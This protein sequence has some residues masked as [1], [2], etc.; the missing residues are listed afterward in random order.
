[1][2][3]GRPGLRQL[4]EISK[5]LTRFESAARTVS[6]VA[7][8]LAQALPLRSIVLMLATKGRAPIQIVAWHAEGVSDEGLGAAKGHAEASY[9]Y[10]AGLEPFGAGGAAAQ[11]RESDG[12]IVLPLVVEHSA[13][14]GIVQLDS[15]A[16]L[17]EPDLLFANAAVNQ[18][19]VALDRAAAIEGRQAAADAIAARARERRELSEATRRRYEEFLAML[20]HE[21]RNPLAPI[22][23]AVRSLQLPGTDLAAQR[24]AADVIERQAKRLARLIDDLVDVARVVT[25]KINFRRERILLSSVVDTAVETVRP[26]MEERGHDFAV[27]LQP[28]PIWLQA[29]AT[30]L[31]Q[32]VVNLLTNAAKYTHDGGRIELTVQ[33]AEDQAV[34]R[35]R[36]TGAGIAPELLPRMF[37]L[38][39]QGDQ[40]LDRA[41][42]G[43]GVGLSLVR[44]I[45]ELHGG[46]VKA[47]SVVGQ[48]SEFIVRLPLEAAEPAASPPAAP[49]HSVA[50]RRLRILVVDDSI[51]TAQGLAML[52]QASNHDVRTAHDGASAVKT[53]LDYRPDVVFLDIGLPEMDGYA[54]AQRI[55]R[56]P[57][58]QGAVLVAMTG[59]GHEA[60]RQRS[61]DAGFDHHLA[62]PADFDDVERILAAVPERPKT[63]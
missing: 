47:E 1:M 19:A 3:N 31:E 18:L 28:E 38:F 27:S 33:Q 53:A 7:Q 61:R 40:S 29:D 58:L 14:F 4:Y 36:D 52:L 24:L 32:V 46:T 63:T 9:E 20:A 44:R 59:Y 62:K 5:L 60:H 26:L 13:I 16:R 30:R 39:T 34:L 37:E 54:V 2:D 57:A 21:L 6:T 10:L 22:V 55:R 41:R 51:E 48:G 8:L 17:E 12:F 45:V 23:Y 42:G 15:A 35:I 56:E 49:A 43:L 50:A 25:G 11:A